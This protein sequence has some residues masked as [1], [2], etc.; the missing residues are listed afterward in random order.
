MYTKS[1]ISSRDNYCSCMDTP[2][3]DYMVFF[4][5]IIFLRIFVL[6]FS[7]WL[8][9]SICKQVKIE[10]YRFFLILGLLTTYFNF[11]CILLVKHPH[12]SYKVSRN[13]GNTA[14]NSSLKIYNV[15]LKVSRYSLWGCMFYLHKIIRL[16]FTRYLWYSQWTRMIWIF[17]FL[18]MH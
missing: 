15:K 5:T 12:S 6:T 18:A 16:T 11:Y 9:S 1:F 4:N 17:L 10:K 3:K 7:I 2:K 13:Y 8:F 14:L